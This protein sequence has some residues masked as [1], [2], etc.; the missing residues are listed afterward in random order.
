[1]ANE[2]I[3]DKIARK[4]IIEYILAHTNEEVVKIRKDLEKQIP[5]VRE[6]I[7]KE[8]NFKVQ[9]DID[10]LQ[11]ELSLIKRDLEKSKIQLVE[12]LGVFTAILAFIVTS[13]QI[14]VK[15]TALLDALV[16]IF[17]IGI[18]LIL[19]IFLLKRIIETR[20][21]KQ[22]PGPIEERNIGSWKKF[23][24]SLNLFLPILISISLAIL[25]YSEVII[26][27]NLSLDFWTI[28]FFAS[29]L[30]FIVNTLA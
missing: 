22:I 20:S 15:F 2:K 1:M 25:A 14:A 5:Q 10:N 28:L 7:A 9:H 12:V 19:F 4:E 26:K 21:E 17:S 30:V 27:Q 16:L 23:R 29:L 8:I 24:N 18:I 11:K 6:E 3:K 13:I